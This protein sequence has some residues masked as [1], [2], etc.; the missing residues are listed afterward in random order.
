MK[1]I[2]LAICLSTGFAS[3]NIKETG[4]PSETVNS[5]FNAMKQGN[6]EEM[7][8]HITKADV[9]MLEGM[10]NMMKNVNPEALTTIKEKVIKEMKEKVK[11]I[12]YRLKNEKIDG[13]NA[14]VE[15]EVVANG[16]TTSHNL[17]LVKENGDWKI[18]L[19]NPGNEMFNSMKGN[20]GAAKKDLD[21]ALEKIKSI[22]PDSLKVIMDSLS[23]RL[24]M[25]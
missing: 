12:N 8:K 15:A 24:Q 10:E 1:K 22:P 21:D 20:L 4:A 25:R 14:T 3:C 13:N 19:G 16:K 18:S 2:I 11:D 6:I 17:V 9:N 7:K 23:K 5:M